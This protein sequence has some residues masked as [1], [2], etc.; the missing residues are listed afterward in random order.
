MKR[1]GN[2]AIHSIAS[3]DRFLEMYVCVGLRDTSG[4]WKL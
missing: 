3:D 2:E 4:M 1:F